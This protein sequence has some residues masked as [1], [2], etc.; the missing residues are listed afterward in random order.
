MPS[1]NS[2]HTPSTVLSG[3]LHIK[4]YLFWCF[5]PTV[6]REG[7]LPVEYHCATVFCLAHRFCENV[8]PLFPIL[9]VTAIGIVIVLIFNRKYTYCAFLDEECSLGFPNENKCMVPPF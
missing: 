1:R 9:Y 7:L 4:G 8:I 2:C 6:W 5:R 3:R